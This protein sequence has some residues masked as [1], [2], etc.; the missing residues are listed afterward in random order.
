MT[1]VLGKF[2]GTKELLDSPE[3][4]FA[5]H[6]GTLHSQVPMLSVCDPISSV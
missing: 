4:V 2:S 5:Q 3:Y 1:I 6:R